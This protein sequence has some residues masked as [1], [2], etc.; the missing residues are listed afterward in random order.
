MTSTATRPSNTD[1]P[2][3]AL[4]GDAIVRTVDLSAGYIKRPVVRDVNCAFRCGELVGIVGP[5]GCGKSTLLKTISGN[6]MPM[7]GQVLLDNQPLADM[8]RRRRARLLAMLPQHPDS[9]PGMTVRDLV[10]CGRAPHTRWFEPFDASDRTAID[11]AIRNCELDELADRPLAE[12]SGGER[13]RAWVAMTLAQQ[14]RV[15]LLDEPTSALDIGHQLDVMHLLQ[16][17][18]NERGL[19]VTVVMHDINLA[20]RFCDRVLVMHR[21]RLV[22]ECLND[23]ATD[24]SLLERVF[25]VAIDTDGPTDISRHLAF[26]RPSK[27]QPCVSP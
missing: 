20:L 1:D 26:T 10:H 12:I 15:L 2:H 24:W 11:H 6:L 18:V 17:L 22:G 16:Y 25:G 27:E 13:Q 9:P 5:N 19:A 23:G 8:P 4:C 3:H 21:G 14:T 7:A